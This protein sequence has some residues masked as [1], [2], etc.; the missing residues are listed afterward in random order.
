MVGLVGL[1]SAGLEDQLSYLGDSLTDWFY[2]GKIMGIV[3]SGKPDGTTTQ[4]VALVAAGETT[5][6][7]RSNLEAVGLELPEASTPT[8]AEVT[9]GSQTIP[10]A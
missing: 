5:E 2:E 3:V 7:T 10:R 9:D 8:L 1:S 6:Q 4:K